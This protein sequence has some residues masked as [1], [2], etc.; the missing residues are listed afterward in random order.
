MEFGARRTVAVL[1]F[2]QMAVF[3]TA[4]PC[5]VFGI[6]RS[7]MGAPTYGLFLCAADPPP[8]RTTEG[9]FTIDTPHDLTALPRADTVIVPAWRD[10]EERPPDHMLDALRQAYDRGARIASLCS[11]AFVL[12]HAGLLDGRRA[13]THWM[14]AGRLAQLFPKVEVDPS[15]LYIDEGQVLTS[16]GTA[17]GIDLCLHMVRLDHGAEAANLFARRMVVPPHRSGGQAQYVE[18]PLPPR[19]D[20]D[21]LGETMTWAVE[22]LGET[23]TVQAM[24]AHAH[25]SARTFARQFLAMTGTS[26]LRWL[27]VQRV[28]AAQR[29][30]ENDDLP[31]DRVAEAC[32][33]GLAAN[34]RVH[35]GRV[36]GT[37]P[38]TYRKM[39]RQRATDDRPAR[40]LGLTAACS[41]LT[42]S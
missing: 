33:L 12:A 42:A 35:F 18:A 26:P 23:L 4:V 16:A 14:F 17:A 36:V 8:L 1:V 39:F 24:A 3:E 9:G 6:D 31:I 38:S 34:L 10:I 2:D 40:A 30:L 20:E 19:M 7:A 22:H 5:E 13:T 41:N 15:V 27:L 29:L 11:G 37:S 21:P 25:L 32:G 28:A